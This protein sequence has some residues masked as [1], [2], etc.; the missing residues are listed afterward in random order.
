M[1][2]TF[3][4]IAAGAALSALAACVETGGGTG[5]AAQIPVAPGGPPFIEGVFSASA[6]ATE[7][8]QRALAAQT[9]GG[10]RVVGSE[11]SEANHAVY[12]RVGANGA[13]WRCLVSAD[14]SNPSTMFM[15]SEGFL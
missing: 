2:R 4:L 15:G 11:S 3:K 5:T 1:T 8:C 13:P 6:A 12:M 14:G 7:S 10:V 9:T